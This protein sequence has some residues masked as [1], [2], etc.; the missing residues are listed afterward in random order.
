MSKCGIYKITNLKNNNCYIGQSINIIQRWKDHRKEAKDIY[1]DKKE[2]P[3]Y[4]A[5]KKYGIEN[6]SFEILEECKVEELNQKEK[7]YIEK[8]DS[9]HNGYNQTLG[10]DCNSKSYNPNLDAIYDDLLNSKITLKNIAKKYGYCYT[11]IYMINTGQTQR[12][13]GY[14]F[15]LRKIEEKEYKN[16]CKICGKKIWSSNKSKICINCQEKEKIKNYPCREEL[17][18]KIRYLTLKEVWENYNSSRKGLEKW[19]KYYNLP[20]KKFEIDSYSDEEWNQL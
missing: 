11:T 20:Y 4:K 1:S 10:G 13:D 9:F 17:K 18:N 7:E 2:Y 16:K 5:I 6:F 19:C 14:N 15:P 8:Y 3:L 12:K